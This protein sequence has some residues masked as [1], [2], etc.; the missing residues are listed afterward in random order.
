MIVTSVQHLIDYVRDNFRI[1]TYKTIQDPK[2]MKEVVTCEIYTV[3]GVV[4]KVED[5]PNKIDKKV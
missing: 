3:K 5:R 2:T 4:E 1:R